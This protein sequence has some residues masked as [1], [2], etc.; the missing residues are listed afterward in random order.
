M[1]IPRLR[2]LWELLSVNGCIL[3]SIDDNEYNNLK[4]ICNELLGEEFYISTFVWRRRSSSSMADKL[5]SVDHEYVICYAKSEFQ[6][7]KGNLK[8]Y[9]SYSNPDND[10][11]GD[12]TPGDLT[13]GMTKDQRP[14]QYYDLIDPY[15][16]ISYSAN[17]KRVWSFIPSSME[18]EIKMG[19][20]IFTKDGSGMPMQKRYKANLKSDVN[21]VS[22]WIKGN[23]DDQESSEIFELSTGLNSQG[24]K[25]LQELF[26]PF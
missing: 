12:W 19:R 6:E 26:K 3:I 10:P 24:T 17:P 21:P 13:V 9:K 22:T 18:N 4:S 23:K 20:V 16:G 7:F 1:I 14:N 25:E 5:V 15:T 11:K 8:D 2:L